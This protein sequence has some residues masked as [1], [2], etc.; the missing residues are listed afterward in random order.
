MVKPFSAICFEL[1]DKYMNVVYNNSDI[2]CLFKTLNVTIIRTT[3]IQ[4]REMTVCVIKV[5][6]TA[7]RNSDI[8]FCQTH[9]SHLWFVT[10]TQMRF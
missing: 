5:F 4:R 9:Y 7:M 6:V 3:F 8:S 10:V 2:T 1:A